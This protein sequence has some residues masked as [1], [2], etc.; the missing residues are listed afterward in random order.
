M[1]VDFFPENFDHSLVSII[2]FLRRS[3]N[4]RHRWVL[5]IDIEAVEAMSLAEGD[6][7]LGPF[8]NSAFARVEHL[9]E[10]SASVIPATDGEERLCA[11]FV[12]H[13]SG[14]HRLVVPFVLLDRPFAALINGPSDKRKELFL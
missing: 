2:V 1:L 14:V 11:L 4:S 10:S 3:V 6:G 8:S 13:E 12:G 9:G 7:V 5:P